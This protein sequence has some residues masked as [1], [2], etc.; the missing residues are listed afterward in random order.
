MLLLEKHCQ[1]IIVLATSNEFAFPGHLRVTVLETLSSTVQCLSLVT[2]ADAGG[3]IWPAEQTPG[4]YVH[5]VTRVT[6]FSQ[7][8][9]LSVLSKTQT[10]CHLM[11]SIFVTYR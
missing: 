1:S 6:R 5:L 7:A 11:I 4:H 9:V 8:T 3:A 10:V 2:F